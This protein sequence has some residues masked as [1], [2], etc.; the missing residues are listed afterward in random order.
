MSFPVYR[1]APIIE[2][3]LDVRVR[4]PEN[5]DLDALVAVRDAHYPDVSR[6]PFQLQ[7]KIEWGDRPDDTGKQHLNTP[8]G[9]FL[10]SADQKQILQARL[11][12]FTFNRLAPY[13]HWESFGAEA[14]RLW[15]IYKESVKVEQ[16]EA[17]SLSYM[18]E[19]LIPFQENVED[20]LNAF[21]NVP[22]DLPSPLTS[23]SLGFQSQIE[24]DNGILHVA[25]SIGPQRREGHLTIGLFIQAIK[26][27]GVSTSLIGEEELWTLFEAL[28]VAKSSAF[29]ACI[30]DK[31]REMIR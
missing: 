18:N 22:K 12:G 21:I 17:I 29:E 28:R 23:F 2:A 7:V 6:E 25:E 10:R 31:V 8:L 14:R 13:E 19:I 11:D 3:A 5:V 16:I 30:T 4:T 27:L 26:F 24:G 1:N 15:N 20:Y 9:Y